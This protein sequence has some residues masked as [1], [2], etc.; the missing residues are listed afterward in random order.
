MVSNEVK[1]KL[2][3]AV[4][5]DYLEYNADNFTEAGAVV[6]I[7]AIDTIACFEDEEDN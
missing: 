6:L 4:V 1:F 5:R 2:I 7:N 3:K